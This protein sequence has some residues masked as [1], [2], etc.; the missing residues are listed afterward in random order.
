MAKEVW[1]CP[2]G[3]I[4]VSGFDRLLRRAGGRAGGCISELDG[5]HVAGWCRRLLRDR[6]TDGGMLDHLLLMELGAR[7][8]YGIGRLVLLLMSF[9]GVMMGVVIDVA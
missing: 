5:R 3:A 7:S 4:P 2:L 1:A 6:T 9:L 8:T